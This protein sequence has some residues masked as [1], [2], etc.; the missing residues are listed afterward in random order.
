MVKGL[1]FVVLKFIWVQVKI[2]DLVSNFFFSC[3]PILKKLVGSNGPKGWIS[4]FCKI[5]IDSI[6]VLP[7][8]C[9][10]EVCANEG[11]LVDVDQDAMVD[12]FIS[13][14]VEYDRSLGLLIHT[15]VVKS[16]NLVEWIKIDFISDHNY[17]PNVIPMERLKQLLNLTVPWCLR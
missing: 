3:R 2:L 14:D 17:R 1:Y 12:C 6:E 9:N 5:I 13:E 15:I 4:C 11:A 8:D 7:N 16:T 10:V